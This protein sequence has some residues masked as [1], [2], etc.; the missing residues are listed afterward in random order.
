MQFDKDSNGFTISFLVAM[1]CIVAIALSLIASSL[2]PFIDK[3]VMVDKKKRILKSVIYV[4][5]KEE[6]KLFTAEWVLAEYDKRIEEVAVDFEG[7]TKEGTNAFDI[8]FKKES[9][10]PESERT[11]P[12][13][14]YSGENEKYYIIPLVGMGLWDEVSGYLAMKTDFK[15]MKGSAFD[16]K[17][18]TPGLGAE[19][20]KYWF[21]EQFQNKVLLDVN[22]QYVFEILKGRGNKLNESQVDGVTGATITTNGTEEML[23][24]CVQYY[25]P[26]FK[27]VKSQSL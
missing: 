19:I 18:E 12:V 3:N 8:D 14:I 17:G 2:K 15:S 21:R 27:K 5:E 7:N 22:D 6:A 11:L 9:R 25:L 20:S 16:H 23:K 4:D 26:Y 10:L 1:V 13:F 24:K